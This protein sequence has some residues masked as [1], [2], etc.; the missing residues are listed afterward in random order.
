MLYD[1]FSDLGFV[2]LPFCQKCFNLRYYGQFG[3]VDS[4]KYHFGI[5][6]YLL[7]TRFF[8]LLFPEIEGWKC[9]YVVL[10]DVFYCATVFYLTLDQA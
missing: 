4:E 2:S 7:T 10:L 1:T 5:L 3:Y 6:T 9:C 8:F